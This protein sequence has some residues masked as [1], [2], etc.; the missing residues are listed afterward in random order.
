M[1]LKIIA[2]FAASTLLMFGGC[3]AAPKAKP[4]SAAP[5]AKFDGMALRSG[6]RVELK[7]FYAPE[8]N[9]TQQIMPNG[10]LSLQLI[11]DVQ[12][13]GKA[14]GDLAEELKTAY[15]QHLKY[16]N[17]SVIV[18]EMYQRKVYVTGE[19]IQPG[20]VDLAG[21]LSPLEAIMNRGG[22]AMTTA[23]TSS[24]IVIRHEG[25]KRVG[26]KIDLKTAMAGGESANFQLQ[27]QD[28]VYVPRTA[29]VNMNNFLEQYVTNMIPQSGFIY[30]RSTGNSTIGINTA[31]N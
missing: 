11:G 6:D 5:A 27:P 25:D 3:D 28:I 26:Y 14:P 18:R 21:E 29:V 16:P 20:L 17:V 15:S 2:A 19:V 7:F 30:T 10:K 22:F 1:N 12:A 8:L 9:D 24:V 31:G 23:E 13:A 4:A